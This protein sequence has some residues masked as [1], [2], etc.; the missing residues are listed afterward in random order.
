MGAMG[1]TGILFLIDELETWG[2]AERHLYEL[3]R[4]LDRGRFRPQVAVLHGARQ[5]ER[6]RAVGLSVHELGVTRIY[7]ATGARALARLVALLRREEVGLLVTYHTA[8]DL[9]GPLAA[10]AAG[11]P[12][13]SSRRDVGFTKKPAHVRAQR[14]INHLVPAMIAVADAVRRAVVA[15]EA[16]PAGRIHVVHNGVDTDRY[17]PRESP[18]RAELGIGA[19][20]VLLGTLAN[21]DPIKGYDVLAPAV[22]RLLP[23]FPA[24]VVMFGEGPLLEEYRR[25]LA[26][27]GDRVLLPGSRRDVEHILWALD[28]FVLASH[29]EGL[30]N[31]IL[32]AMAAG[33]PV[34]ATAVGGN[35]ELVDASTGVLVPPGDPVALADALEALCRDGAG[36]RRRGAAARARAVRDFDYD[37][38]VGRYQEVFDLV[39]EESPGRAR[40]RAAKHVVAGVWA[41]TAPVR[42]AARPGAFVALCYHRVAPTTAGW[43]P[44]LVVSV[45]TFRRQLRALSDR[46]ELVTCGELHR[47]LAAGSRRRLCAVSFDDGYADNLELAQ[48][49]LAEAGVPWT[50][51]VASD[52]VDHGG[53]LWFERLATLLRP[54]LR[55]PALAAL[56]RDHAALREIPAAVAGAP[57]ARAAVRAAV[58]LLKDQPTAAREA[59]EAALVAAFGAPPAAELPRFLDWDGVRALRAAGVEIGG[60]T[61]S[62][63][64]LPRTDPDRARA[65]IVGGRERLEAELGMP[66]AGF[67]SPNGDLDD[68]AVRLVGEAGF[69]W[70]YTA[71]PA[72]WDGDP[73]RIPRRVVAEQASRAFAGPFSERAF[74]AEVEGAYDRLR[75][76]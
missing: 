57:T 21:F 19:D 67:A 52:P 12:T 3:C 30:S 70:A 49:L 74:L 1:P 15:A 37:V 75:G 48:P 38:M 35:P 46:Y 29:S 14:R 31:A 60:H 40:R 62:H 24:R 54:R 72:P 66:V 68:T 27:F 71:M 64:I 53:A 17:A 51:F 13:I 34:C 33:R 58:R 7:G 9:L 2:G 5:V 55:D 11:I 50:L 41:A 76:E 39:R 18:L 4:A 10:L 23:R 56:G 65:E 42:R 26:P 16:Y 44:A 61:R 20:E 59:A 6:F 45:E 47:A 28:V 25:R 8:A 69:A 22:E 63:P 36:R 32:E 43:D 73:Y